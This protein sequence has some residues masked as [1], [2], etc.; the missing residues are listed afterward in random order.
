M[1]LLETGSLQIQLVKDFKMRASWIRVGPI[2]SDCCPSRKGWPHRDAQRRGR[3]TEAGRQ[4]QELE[5]A[6]RGLRVLGEPSPA[7][8]RFHP[9]ASGAVRH[10]ISVFKAARLVVL[11]CGGP[12]TLTRVGEKGSGL[13]PPCEGPG[14]GS[15]PGVVGPCVRGTQQ[16][17]SNTCVPPVGQ[18]YDFCLRACHPPEVARRPR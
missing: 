14:L 5:E 8:L 18:T 17:L 15:V 11:C 2:S 16:D 3:N 10:Y 9:L 7:T 12:R 1:T 6:G 13:P 4:F